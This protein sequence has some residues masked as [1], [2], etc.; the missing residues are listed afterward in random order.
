MSARAT[1]SLIDR[2]DD[3]DD[4][5]REILGTVPSWT[6]R[7]GSMLVLGVVVGLVVLAWLVRFPEVV[8]APVHVVTQNPAVPVVARALG[9]IERLEVAD[10][11]EVRAGARLAVLGSTAN[12]DDVA[13]LRQQLD[14]LAGA[15]GEPAELVTAQL[16][17]RL[18]VG[19]MQG[20]LATLWQQLAELEYLRRRNPYNEKLRASEAALTAQRQLR[21]RL[22]EHRSTPLAGLQ[23]AERQFERHREA[24]RLQVLSTDALDESAA[25]LLRQQ[26]EID[27]LEAQALANDAEQAESKFRAADIEFERRDRQLMLVGRITEAHQ[28]LDA[29]VR[30]WEQTYVLSAPTSGRVSLLDVWS[31][32]QVVRPDQEVMYVVPQSPKLVG[33][34]SVAQRGLGRVRPGQ[35]AFVSFESHPV[36]HY[37]RVQGEVVSLSAA[38]RGDGYVLLLDFPQGLV[39]SYR[40]QLRFQQNM[41]GTVD[42]VTD[43]LSLLERLVA[44]IRQLWVQS[45]GA[46]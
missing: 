34:V 42:I 28:K 31:S 15:L 14:G 3:L 29:A 23:L 10:G 9:R 41:A 35:R 11:A 22:D 39:T 45:R 7:W 32:D 6:V 26:A 25:A 16:D 20:L 44:P 24:S 43:D 18:A 5:V 4:D 8:S 33:R 27:A 13:R 38:P 46:G 2:L 17:R 36:A 12:P 19:D 21:A 37:G 1:P 30:T 40:H